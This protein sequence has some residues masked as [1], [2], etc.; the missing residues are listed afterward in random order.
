MTTLTLA[1]IDNELANPV[2]NL[3]HR[4]RVHILEYARERAARELAEALLPENWVV[5]ANIWNPADWSP[6]SFPARYT[7]SAGPN[8]GPESEWV[9]GKGDTLTAAYLALAEALKGRAL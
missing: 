6:K 8:T 9:V 1:Q 7:A 5:Q 2:P 4:P 3:A